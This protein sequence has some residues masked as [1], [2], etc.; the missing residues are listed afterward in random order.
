LPSDW[1]TP[2]VSRIFDHLKN[3][4]KHSKE[5]VEQLRWRLS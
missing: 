4:C 2:V 1:K 3:V 5:L